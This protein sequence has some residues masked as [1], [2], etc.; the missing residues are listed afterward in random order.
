MSSYRLFIPF[1]YL[2][3]CVFVIVQKRTAGREHMVIG[4]RLLRPLVPRRSSS[5]VDAKR[6][7]YWSFESISIRF[8]NPM[9]AAR[10]AALA[11]KFISCCIC[12]QLEELASAATVIYTKAQSDDRLR[13]NRQVRFS[14]PRPQGPK[15][16]GGEKR[17][18]FFIFWGP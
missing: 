15:W 7:S 11:P 3:L 9:C 1:P 13:S 16:S 18:S 17:E 2:Q 6:V 5:I 4:K 10:D 12:H 8:L 14:P